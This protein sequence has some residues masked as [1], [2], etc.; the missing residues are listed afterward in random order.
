MEVLHEHCAGLDVHKKTVVACVLHSG[1]EGELLKETRTF[2]TMLPELERLRDWLVEQA[3]THVGME[4]TGVYWKPVY[5][6]LEGHFTL[7]VVNAEHMRAVPG[8][9]TDVKDAEWIADLVRHGLVRSSFIP[10]RS[11]R[12][13]REL[14]RF[15]TALIQD[16]SRAVNRLQKTLEGANIKLAAVL[17]DV[18]GVSGQRI[19]EALLRDETDPES[20]ADL[21]HWRVQVKR[22]ALE[23]ALMG[24]LGRRLSFVVGQQL[25]QIRS[26]DDQIEACDEE[27]A[28]QMRPFVTEVERLDAI[29]GIGPRTAETLIAE[30]GVDLSRW[31]TASHLAAWAGMCPGNKASGG[32]RRPARTRKGNPW[33]RR[34]LTEAAWA[35]GRSKRSYLGARFR[36]WSA[37]KGLKRAI[38]ALGHEILI[39]VYYLMTRSREY[40][41]LGLTYLEERNREALQKQAIRQLQKLGYEV[42]LT[43][44]GAAA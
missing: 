14:T 36:R 29:P 22:P 39:I 2:S 17:T 20:L 16:R 23:Q 27:V 40:Q 44:Q 5:N 4:A 26:L 1:S 15:R 34:A 37:R 42:T 7:L 24:R 13:L 19:L 8:R 38:V 30:L 12:E 33:V 11:Q 21:A 28:E 25:Q 41:D 9:K 32:K 10:E 6:I 3:C 18:T 35:A 43:S 31:P